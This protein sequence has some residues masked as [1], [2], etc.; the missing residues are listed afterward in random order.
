[1][2]SITVNLPLPLV[3]KD[4]VKDIDH[5]A[6]EHKGKSLLKF[7]VYDPENNM[8]LEMFSRTAKV[9]PSD[10]FLKFFEDRPEMSY[11]IN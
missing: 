6:K 10:A 11:R 8:H 7:N 9:H 1:V 2:K 3:N 5:L 4:L